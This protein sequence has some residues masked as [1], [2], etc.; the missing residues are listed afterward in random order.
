[1]AKP[2]CKTLNRTDDQ[3]LPAS[4]GRG[5]GQAK[6]WMHMLRMWRSMERRTILRSANRDTPFLH[7][8]VIGPLMTQYDVIY[9]WKT[10][11]ASRTGTKCSKRWSP[12]HNDRT[13]TQLHFSYR[14]IDLVYLYLVFNLPIS[15][16]LKDQKAHPQI[17]RNISRKG[18][19]L[20]EPSIEPSMMNN[21]HE[22]SSILEESAMFAEVLNRELKYSPLLH[23]WNPHY[24]LL[25]LC[26]SYFF[27]L[28][29]HIEGR[30]RR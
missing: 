9:R 4:S 27:P 5:S 30:S 26:K 21:E 7:Y 3:V 22:H 8:I 14:V 12:R 20:E 16:S 10:L 28:L 23:K 15:P 29:V 19:P 25:K 24:V 2:T 17:E 13:H 18:G 6:L 11:R 1:M